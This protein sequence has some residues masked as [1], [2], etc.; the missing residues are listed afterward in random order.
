M[1]TFPVIL[2]CKKFTWQFDICELFQHIIVILMD[3][4]NYGHLAGDVVDPIM[5]DDLASWSFA[6]Q[7]DVNQL[8]NMTAT[9]WMH[10]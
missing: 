2:A 10:I 9:S 1:P 7:T 6:I 8:Q 4:L 5:Q 3:C